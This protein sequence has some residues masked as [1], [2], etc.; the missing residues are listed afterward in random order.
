M[1]WTRV[2]GLSRGEVRGLELAE[3]GMRC[4]SILI[5]SD[6]DHESYSNSENETIALMPTNLSN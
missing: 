3:A 6:H 5:A 1:S 4:M 2:R